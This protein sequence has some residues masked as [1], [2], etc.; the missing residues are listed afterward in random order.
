MKCPFAVYITIIVTYTSA[1]LDH[2]SESRPYGRA[3]LAAPF[4]LF[5]RGQGAPEYVTIAPTLHT[6][7]C[8]S[9]PPPP[10]PSFSPCNKM[11]IKRTQACCRQQIIPRHGSDG[12]SHGLRSEKSVCDYFLHL[13]EPSQGLCHTR[14]RTPSSLWQGRQLEQTLRAQALG[15]RACGAE[16]RWGSV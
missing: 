11:T 10:P 5:R 8:P 1:S 14:R 3:A 7:S 2:D 6:I 12:N 15:L 13:P 9:L 4:G 16:P